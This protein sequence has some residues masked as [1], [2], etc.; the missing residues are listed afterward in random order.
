[1]NE[2][3]NSTPPPAPPLTGPLTDP[4]QVVPPFQ[5]PGATSVISP[6]SSDDAGTTFGSRPDGSWP[7]GSWSDGSW[8]DGS[9]PQPGPPTAG[10]GLWSEQAHVGFGSG[11]G[12]G[13]GLTPNKR[14]NPRWQ[15]LAVVV[16]ALAMLGTG[17]VVR[18]LVGEGWSNGTEQ[19]TVGASTDSSNAPAASDATS[20]D[21]TTSGRAASD[22]RIVP[23][24]TDEPVAAVA[25]ALSPAVVQVQTSDGLGSGVIYDQSGLLMT[26]AHV[27]GSSTSVIVSLSDGSRHEATVLG[28]DEHTDIAVVQIADAEGLTVASL[29]SEAPRV[30][31]MAIAL[32]SP[33]GL[34]G[35]VTQGIVSAVDR[36]V[37]NQSGSAVN[38]IQTD[39]PIN[40][41][42]SGGALANR[43]GEVIGINSSIYSRSG[44]NSGIG[45]AVPIATAKSVAD[46]IVNG[47][48]LEKAGLG[49]SGSDSPSGDPGAYVQTVV[50]GGAAE[51]AGLAQGDLITA[52][53]GSAIKNMEAL[54]AIIG[55]HSPGDEITVTFVRNG[56][57]TTTR[58]TLGSSESVQRE[59]SGRSGIFGN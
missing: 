53:D 36:P 20:D 10:Y 3:W 18:G 55:S 22:T 54:R 4:S 58:V 5:V 45:F 16:V 32:G 26:N 8:F 14:R 47:G 19:A 13:Q 30:G 7:D 46:K 44:D 52:V 35:T 50:S 37:D 48:S 49:I 41:G 11:S 6:G 51:A 34:D 17:F 56:R 1:M 59:V 43:N 2:P 27:V 12:A 29:A 9:A 15:I 39:A 57:S 42:N 31:Q 28:A 23:S 25:E 38:M 40:P 33:F 24:D 21:S